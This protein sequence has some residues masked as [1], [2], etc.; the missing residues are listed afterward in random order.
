LL[1]TYF[2]PG[3]YSFIPR[4]LSKMYEQPKSKGFFKVRIKL[5]PYSCARAAPLLAVVKRKAEEEE[6][7]KK[8]KELSLGIVC[9]TK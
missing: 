1:A 7:A 4:K 6:L 5:I 3:P 2:L 9:T 8:K